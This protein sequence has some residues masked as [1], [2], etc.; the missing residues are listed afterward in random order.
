MVEVNSLGFAGS[1]QPTALIRLVRPKYDPSE[2]FCGG[3]GLIFWI[4]IAVGGFF[5]C[6]ASAA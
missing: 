4:A 3:V 1:A 5:F 6:R 2:S